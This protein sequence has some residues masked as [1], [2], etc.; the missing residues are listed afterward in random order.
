[1]RQI[2][3]NQ[4]QQWANASI[5]SGE[6]A[7]DLFFERLCS[8]TRFLQPGDLFIA[9]RGE[10]FDGHDFLKEAV[11]AGASAVII[12]QAD[13]WSNV[14]KELGIRESICVYLVE[15]TRAAL[16]DIASG[17]R[18]QLKSTVIAVTGSVGKTSTRRMI[19]ACLEPSLS[20]HQTEANLNN[21]I[22][23]SQTILAAQ[24]D[25]EA[26]V[27]EMGMR[28]SGE[29][30]QLSRIAS[31]DI[32]I[33]TCIGWSHIGELGSQKAILAA[34]WEL[35]ESLKPG[36]LLIL[37][38]EDPLLID[39][40]RTLDTSIRLA[41]VCTTD[42]GFKQADLIRERVCLL[43]AAKHIEIESEQTSFDAVIEQDGQ[44]SQT[45]VLLPYPGSHH[46]QNALFGLTVA[47]AMNLNLTRS[48]T[49]AARYQAVGNRQRII[50]QQQI[51]IMDDSYNAAPE[52]MEAAL[53]SLSLIAG[54]NRKIAVLGCMLELGAFTP[55]VHRW[56]GEQVAQHG[57]SLLLAYGPEAEDYLIGARQVNS[58]IPSCVCLDHDEITARLISFIR[59][60]DFI[61]IKGSRGYTMEKVTELLLKRLNLRFE[62]GGDQ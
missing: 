6:P 39:A 22:G 33:I 43:A 11:E 36:S 50:E 38:A 51:T 28:H 10:L 34:K 29:I 55:D 31:P 26:I 18:H 7:G 5:I 41:L 59:P 49:G 47:A 62:N 35:A 16:Q 12:D 52:S 37:N 23:L 56:V 32:G 45:A 57:Y 13:A 1:M 25:D 24:P 14:S 21:E 17:Y 60:G 3:C 9:L 42:E 4:I 58:E 15:E 54:S 2:S 30:R 8:D 46:I 53:E 48:A 19:A 61:L 20:V 44:T 27:V 40:S